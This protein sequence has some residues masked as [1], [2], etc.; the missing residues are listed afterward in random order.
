MMHGYFATN[1]T[2]GFSEDAEFEA[3]V[4]EVHTLILYDDLNHDS[5]AAKNGTIKTIPI[6][7]PCN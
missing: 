3:F 1:S 4:P 6:S 7:I 5:L 2:G